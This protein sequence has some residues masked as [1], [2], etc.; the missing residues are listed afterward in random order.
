MRL[1]DKNVRPVF[2]PRQRHNHL[3]AAIPSSQGLDP[4]EQRVSLSSA[5][6]SCLSPYMH[7]KTGLRHSESATL[8][9]LQV[10]LFGHP[11]CLLDC[12]TDCFLP[13]TLELANELGNPIKLCFCFSFSLLKSGPNIQKYWMVSSKSGLSDA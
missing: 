12:W 8:G 2:N 7:T 4:A 5:W 13:V 1:T 3:S 11:A 9:H 10:F 6:T